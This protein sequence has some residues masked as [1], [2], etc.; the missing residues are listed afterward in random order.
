MP[1][2]IQSTWVKA[3]LFAVLGLVLIVGGLF[4]GLSMGERRG[5]HFFRFSERYDRLLG[6]EEN[7]PFGRP[8]LPG[9]HGV[10]GKV[11]SV[12]TSTLILENPDNIEQD[13]AVSS[14]TD[15]RSGMRPISL[16][17]ITPGQIVVVFGAPNNQGQIEARLIRLMGG[18]RP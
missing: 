13:I 12:S 2:L 14:S 9:I 4:V 1:E 3:T 7:M 6:P 15:V 18:R 8:P 5:S 16:D 17:Q 10:S 11:L